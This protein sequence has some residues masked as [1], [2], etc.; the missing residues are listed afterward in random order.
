MERHGAE[1]GATEIV[2]FE[3]TARAVVGLI[4]LIGDFAPADAAHAF[5]S[6]NATS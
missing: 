2:V 1:A 3:P 4:E 6:V 5:K